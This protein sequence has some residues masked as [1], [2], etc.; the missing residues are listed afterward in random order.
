MADIT[1]CVNCRSLATFDKHTLPI[2]IYS[3]DPL[4]SDRR[5]PDAFT[6]HHLWV[7]LG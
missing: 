4:D 1:Q 6:D 3:H 7:F 2:H 5:M